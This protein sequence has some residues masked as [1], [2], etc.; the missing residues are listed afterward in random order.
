MMPSGFRTVIGAG[1]FLGG[2]RAAR[3]I[4]GIEA[5]TPCKTPHFAFRDCAQD[6]FHPGAEFWLRFHTTAKMVLPV[7]VILLRLGSLFRLLSDY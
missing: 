6:R 4:R 1:R 7:M 3:F 5:T 2:K